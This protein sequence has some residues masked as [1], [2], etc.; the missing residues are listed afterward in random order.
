VQGFTAPD[1]VVVDTGSMFF[2]G[3]YVAISRTTD[4]NKVML[5]KPALASY[6]TSHPEYRLQVLREYARLLALF[7]A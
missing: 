7:P 5:L 4:M 6:F 2:A 1:G 3:D